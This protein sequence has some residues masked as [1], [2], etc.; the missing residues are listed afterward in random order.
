M[1]QAAFSVAL[2]VL[3]AIGG[4]VLLSGLAHA[5]AVT[6][7]IPNPRFRRALLVGFLVVPSVAGIFFL[8]GAFQ[9]HAALQK[10]AGVLAAVPIAGINLVILKLLYRT[11]WVKALVALLATALYVF[12]AGTAA[13][14]VMGMFG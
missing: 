2:K 1:W 5:G 11:T 12:L 3:A 14:R 6:A 8:A 10:V 13:S 4:W 7:A 9:E